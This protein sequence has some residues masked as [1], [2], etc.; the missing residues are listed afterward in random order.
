MKRIIFIGFLLMSLHALAQ[1]SKKLNYAD[2][3]IDVPAG[4][5]ADSDTSIS[6]DNFTVQWTAISEI[7]YEKNVH[8][9][10]IR[11]TEIQMHGKFVSGVQFFS[12]GAK[13][14]GRLYQVKG[15][16]PFKYKILAY[17]IVNKKLVILNM[18][19][20]KQPQQNA[21][22]DDLMRKFIDFEK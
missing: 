7:M 11:Q 5:K 10:M 22:L 6:G 2:I 21:D 20:V 1:Q 9:Q 4:Y 14:S 19:F 16:T 15:D 18:G 3:Q 12:E 13:M 8:K 17:G